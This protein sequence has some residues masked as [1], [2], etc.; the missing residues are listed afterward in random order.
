MMNKFFALMPPS[1]DASNEYGCACKYEYR[2]GTQYQVI[3][4]FYSMRE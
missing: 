2:H 4:D 3:A 1:Y